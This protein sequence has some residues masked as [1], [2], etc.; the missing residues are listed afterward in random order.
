VKP[1]APPQKGRIRQAS[2]VG[3]SVVVTNRGDAIAADEGR[4]E[5][6]R[7]RSVTLSDVM[8]DTGATTLCLPADIVRQLGLRLLEEID[9][10]TATG[11]SRLRVFQDATITVLGQRDT[12]SCVE[13]PEGSPPLLGV[14]PLER[15]GLE[16][17]LVNETLR[18]VPSDR[19][20]FVI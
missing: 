9:V 4:L 19:H 20:F 17:D 8:V 12:F 11:R 2:R 6:A 18:R 16:P 1:E 15:L 14:V 5:A 3:V 10:T 13:L 7:V